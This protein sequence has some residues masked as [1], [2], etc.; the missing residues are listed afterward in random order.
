MELLIKN[1]RVVDFLQDFIGDVYIKDGI[2]HEIGRDLEKN[3]KT[4]D[5]I[6]KV[7]MPSFIDLHAHFREP[8]YTYK[9]DIESGSRAAAK[10]GYTYVNLMP[11]TNPVCSSMDIVNYVINKADEIGLIDVHQA[12]SITRD[13]DGQT[14]NHIDELDEKVKVISEDGKDVMNSKT[15]IKAMEK[16]KE[17]NILV[18]CHCENHDISAMD[19]RLAEDTMTWR[20]ITLAQYTGCP[21]HI[22]H[23]STKKSMNYIIDAKRKGQN[24]TCEVTPH[25][26]ALEDDINYRVN[27]PLRKKEDRDFLIKT[28]REGLVDAI[29]TDHA[30]HSY[31][32]KT[33]GSPGISGIETVFSVCYSYLVK[34]KEIS[35]SKLSEIMSKN[36]S[37][38]MNLNKGQ[39]KIGF[40]GDL[41][42]VNLEKSYKVNSD[43]FLSKGK[44]TPFEGKKLYGQVEKTIKSGK[45]IY[46]LYL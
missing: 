32:D 11:N 41:V 36:P 37:E 3:C 6:G 20:N 29:G 22:S 23:V 5:G 21:V 45:I 19:M 7:L 12:V 17:K 31:E 44:N 13:F 15:M 28:I 24:V 10:G 16:A 14:I 42:L 40:M 33:K 25:H 1:S 27:P 8:G 4:I 35:L 30:P 43:S 9:E 18:M 38:I 46:D 2:I 26:I 39:I 34:K